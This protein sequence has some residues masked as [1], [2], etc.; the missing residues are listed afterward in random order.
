MKYRPPLVREQK[1]RPPLAAVTATLAVVRRL[2]ERDGERRAWFLRG[3][4]RSCGLRA[5]NSYLPGSRGA[6]AAAARR[7][8]MDGV[9]PC[10]ARASACATAASHAPEAPAVAGEADA[11]T[12]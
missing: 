7:P 8:R 6:W 5:W 11:Y 1:H 12:D 4:D 10:R 3:A 9:P 2:L